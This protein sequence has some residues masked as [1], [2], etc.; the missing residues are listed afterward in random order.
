MTEV[1]RKTVVVRT[2]ELYR[3]T[4]GT[5][6]NFMSVDVQKVR[7]LQLQPTNHSPAPLPTPLLL[8]QIM[9][10]VPSFHQFWSLPVQVSVT[11]YLLYRM[12]HWA[13]IAGLVVLVIFVPINMVIASAIGRLTQKM[14]VHKVLALSLSC[15]TVLTHTL[16]PAPSSSPLGRA[17][18]VVQ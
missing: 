14:M 1:M 12:V 16:L 7:A 13:F 4:V 11:L 18:E 6:T 2:A 15:C 10:V 8:P 9:D 3:F 5:V 17:C